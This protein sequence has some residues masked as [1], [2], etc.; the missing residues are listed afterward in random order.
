MLVNFLGIWNKR[1]EKTH[2]IKFRY[3]NSS[4]SLK[5][6][7][8]KKAH[9]YKMHFSRKSVDKKRSG[10]GSGGTGLSSQRQADLHDTS[11]VWRVSSGTA[12]MTQKNPVS[13]DKN[14]GGV[15]LAII[16]RTVL[17]C[18]IPHPGNN[19]GLTNLLNFK[20]SSLSYK[21][22]KQWHYFS[23]WNRHNI[24]SKRL[25]GIRRLYY[26]ICRKF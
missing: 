7:K 21:S 15:Y 14:G 13:K 20:V 25:H 5:L 22:P 26:R 6:L 4:S 10:P 17:C 2:G 19:L 12:R 18:L 8:E 9:F 1:I 3:T 24:R 11:L 16:Q 23:D